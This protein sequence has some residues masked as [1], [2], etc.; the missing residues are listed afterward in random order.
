MDID[1]F[2]LN[3]VFIDIVIIFLLIILLIIVKLYKNSARWRGS[4]SNEA[5]VYNIY[6]KSDLKL[7]NLNIVPKKWNL[8]RNTALKKENSSKPIVI[9][10]RTNHRKKLLHI[11]TEGFVSY[12]F[13]VINISLKIKPQTNY[14]PLDKTVQDETKNLISTI[15]NDL[16]KMSLIF[17]SNYV[18]INYSKSILS[19]N[20]LFSDV[21]NDGMIIINPKINR[22]NI[23]N[24]S[25]INTLPKIKTSFSIIFSKKSILLFGNKNLGN[26]FKQ[27]SK[28]IIN[29]LRFFVFDKA[30][31]SFKYYETIL[32]SKIINLIEMNIIKSST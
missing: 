10:I 20:S 24:I 21:R 12:G 30:R 18:I 9:I 29:K 26:F 14:N 11:L 17:N 5:I 8:V 28:D 7:N 27:Y 23:K 19:Y 22:L 2:R 4:F 13:N 6:T 3:W 25:E 31:M 32:L 15:V 16:K 1:I